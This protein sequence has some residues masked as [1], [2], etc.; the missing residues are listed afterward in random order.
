MDILIPIE[1]AS[2]ELTYKVH[3]CNLLACEGFSCYIGS[4]SQINILLGF[5]T[6][7]IYLDKGYHPKVSDSLYAIIKKNKGTIVSLDEEGAVDYSDSST[8][9]HRYSIDLFKNADFVFLWGE[10]IYDLIKDKILDKNKVK[11]T[12]HPRFDLLKSQ[13]HYIYRKDADRIRERYGKFILINTNMGFGNNIKGDNFVLENYRGRF[14]DIE[15]IIEFDKKKIKVFNSLITK[16]SKVTHKTII[17]RPHPEEKHS[18]YNNFFS[19]LKNVKVVYDNSVVPWLLA[20]EKMIHPDCTTA[21]EAYFIGK[22]PL[23][24]LP[25]DSSNYMVTEVPLNISIQFDDEDLIIDYLR[26]KHHDK[27]AHSAYKDEI[28]EGYFAYSK[29]SLIL[30]VSQLSAI[31]NQINNILLNKLKLH[32][33]IQLKFKILFRNFWKRIKNLKLKDSKLKGFN[34]NTLKLNLNEIQNQ[35]R[36]NEIKLKKINNELFCF[37]KKDI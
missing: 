32:Q 35:E 6:N 14:P 31:K 27:S 3:L 26:E 15:K 29:P 36:I 9:K 34:Y 8:L 5:F 20:C 13:F 16:L 2:R 4:K 25:K 10:K 12:G 24:F 17:I 7:Y 23:S 18:L 1:T 33:I 37:I 28:V 30:I 21:I 22:T 19:N 11:I